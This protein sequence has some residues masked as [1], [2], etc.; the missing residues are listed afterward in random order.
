MS[1]REDLLLA[2]YAVA[3]G[4]TLGTDKM[5]HEFGP[6]V[7]DSVG[8]PH[9]G[10]QFERAGVQVW[11]TGRGWRCSRRGANG[12]HA[13]PAPAEQFR[14]RLFLALREAIKLGGELP[15]VP[16]LGAFRANLAHAI[17]NGET[18]TMGGGEF[19]PAELREVARALGGE[20]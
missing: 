11:N 16:D 4:F 15:A 19:S 12:M 2:A 6:A 14:A 7:F 3:H 18:V 20:G 5:G 10:L 17:A 8:I 1:Y 13:H 9:D